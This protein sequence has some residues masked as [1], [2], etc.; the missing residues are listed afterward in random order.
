MYTNLFLKCLDSLEDSIH[1]NPGCFVRRQHSIHIT[2][3]VGREIK[4]ISLPTRE[5]SAEFLKRHGIIQQYAF[6]QTGLKMYESL[7]ITSSD[8]RG[9]PVQH[10]R[11]VPVEWE[12]VTLTSTQVKRIAAREEWNELTTVVQFTEII[13][14]A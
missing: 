6:T 8:H 4:H 13:K 10:Q 2:Y 11:M 12:D 14:R 7:L 5:T 3:R 9:R 1:T